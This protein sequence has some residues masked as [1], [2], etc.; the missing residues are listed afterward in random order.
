MRRALALR[1]LW[2][3]GVAQQAQLV[4]P[5]VD[6]VLAHCFRVS[7]PSQEDLRWGRAVLSAQL[8][9]IMPW[10]QCL[11]DHGVSIAGWLSDLRS[12]EE[13]VF[14]PPFRVECLVS[15]VLA[16]LPVLA[17]NAG[18]SA[19]VALIRALLGSLLAC[20]RRHLGCCFCLDLCTG[21]VPALAC[22]PC[23]RARLCACRG[24]AWLCHSIYAFSLVVYVVS[25][26]SVPASSAVPVL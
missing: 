25:A 9:R 3:G 21:S 17:K 8:G 13:L 1:D 10:L 14:S 19:P 5:L 7:L 12:L 20:L 16:G 15:S 2:G 23:F 22:L 26:F 24:F 6:P 18:P 4:A 11:L